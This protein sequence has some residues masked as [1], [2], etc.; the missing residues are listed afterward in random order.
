MVFDL[1]LFNLFLF[2]IA[3]QL[4]YKDKGRSLKRSKFNPLYPTKFLIHGFTQDEKE[5]WLHEFKDALLGL[6]IRGY[7]A[8]R[9]PKGYLYRRTLDHCSPPPAPS[10]KIDYASAASHCW[11][12]YTYFQHHFSVYSCI[13][14]RINRT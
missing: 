5:K 14:A 6:V 2:F 7:T 4:D 1:F 9:S 13:I 3:A 11:R 8:G 10:K 12:V